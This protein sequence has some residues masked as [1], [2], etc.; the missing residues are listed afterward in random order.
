MPPKKRGHYAT[1]LRVRKHMEEQKAQVLAATRREIRVAEGERNSI[2]EEQRR[3]LDTA[4]NLAR[5]VFDPSDVRRY[6][7]YERHLAR[8]VVQKDAEI[9]GLK[10]RADKE[11]RDLEEAMK[12]R[13]VAEKLEE[14]T[15]AAYEAYIRK[16]DQKQADETATNYAAMALRAGQVR[17]KG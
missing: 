8:L 11:R 5:E 14:R 17:R 4:G 16:E 9:R 7:Q 2:T 1:L 10:R 15:A 6:Y 12:K 13:R 3:A